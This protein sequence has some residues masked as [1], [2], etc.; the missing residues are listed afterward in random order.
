MRPLNESGRSA[1]VGSVVSE[2]ARSGECFF[3][4]TEVL[5][6]HD[7]KYMPKEV[8]EAIERNKKKIKA[9]SKAKAAENT[10]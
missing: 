3:K 9:E 8:A 10:S 2:K 4:A 6:K 7:E 5:A 1:P